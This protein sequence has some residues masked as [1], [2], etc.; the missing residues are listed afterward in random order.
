MVCFV[1]TLSST[2]LPIRKIFKFS[3]LLITFYVFSFFHAGTAFSFS[4][5]DPTLIYQAKPCGNIPGPEDKKIIV[6][7]DKSGNNLCVS[8]DYL[9]KAHHFALSWKASRAKGFSDAAAF[10][11]AYHADMIDL[12][13]YSPFTFL[14]GK[15]RMQAHYAI[16][17]ELCKNMHFDDN[18]STPAVE[19]AWKRYMYRTFAGLLWAAEKN[20]TAAAHLLLGVS[21]HA[22]EDFYSHSIWINEPARRNLTWFETTQDERKSWTLW[23]GAYEK[24]EQFGIQHHG[25]L[26]FSCSL[27]NNLPQEVISLV[28]NIGCSALSPMSG[29]EESLCQSLEDCTKGQSATPYVGGE[30]V[31]NVQVPPGYVFTLPGVNLDAKW[32]A[33]VGANA[34]GIDISGE[35]AFNIAYQRAQRTAEQWL[36]V[37]GE[38]MG[39][40][41]YAAFWEKVKS[42]GANETK[43]EEQWVSFS[44]FPFIFPMSGPYPHNLPGSCAGEISEEYAELHPFFNKQKF[45]ADQQS[46]NTQEQEFYL[47]VRLKTAYEDLAGTNAQI[48]LH[49]AGQEFLLDYFPGTVSTALYND[50]EKGDD[51]VYWVGPLPYMPS[52]VTLENKVSNVGDIAGQLWN[53]TKAFVENLWEGALKGIAYAVLAGGNDD[54]VSKEHLTFKVSELTNQPVKNIQIDLDGAKLGQPGMGRYVLKGVIKTSLSAGQAYITVTFTS[55]HCIKES[56]SDRFTDSDEPYFH[57]ILAMLPGGVQGKVSEVFEDEK[58]PGNDGFDT[59][60][61]LPNVNVQF[62]EVKM[63]LNGVLALTVVQMENDFETKADREKKNKEYASGIKKKADYTMV[64][65]AEAFAADWKLDDIEIYAFNNA[66]PYLAAGTVLSASDP[67]SVSQWIAASKSSAFTLSQPKKWELAKY[68]APTFFPENKFPLKTVRVVSEQEDRLALEVTYKSKPKE[69]IGTVF[70][71]AYPV[72]NNH[73]KITGASFKFVPFLMTGVATGG[74]DGKGTVHVIRNTTQSSVKSSFIRLIVYKPDQDPIEQYTYDYAYA[75]TWTP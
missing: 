17:A 48:I 38:W 51:T 8:P 9:D 40:A 53:N 54:V 55:L 33:Q 50:F 10:A 74:K 25:K 28:K 42:E 22:L 24:P 4:Y 2:A 67:Q 61:V 62:N 5:E 56:E 64:G 32:L 7:K 1:L 36:D 72:D 46:H 41:G 39:Q 65:F 66:H 21:F 75:R 16:Q 71:G 60:D 29:N 18:Y 12:F 6:D 70:V 69:L 45:Y 27:F 19:C 58:A 52:Q 63:P 14:Q 44:K 68:N 3:F 34:R 23:V 31:S 47:L 43:R 37:L 15:A 13:G 49:A 26:M 73:E 20:D 30:F 59:G 35:D 57:A 11:V